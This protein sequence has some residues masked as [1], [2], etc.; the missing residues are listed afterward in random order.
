VS[1]EWRTPSEALRKIAETPPAEIQP[2][3]DAQKRRIVRAGEDAAAAA[4]QLE[5]ET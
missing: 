1:E 2:M 4:E 5:A 3:T